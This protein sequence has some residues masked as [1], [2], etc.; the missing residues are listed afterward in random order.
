[1]MTD[2]ELCEMLRMYNHYIAAD[3]IEA[4]V[5][6]RDEYHG[7]FVYWRAEAD[8]LREQL[9]AAE[10]REAALLASNDA[11]RKALLANNA[12]HEATKAA[13]KE[14]VEV[15]RVIEADCEADYPPS[16]LAIKY[17]ARAVTAKHGSQK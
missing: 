14:A 4:L 8:G 15:L 13:L 5:K 10:A 12:K 3:R 6:E 11:D 16:H 2:E 1:M 17:A 7:L 9:K